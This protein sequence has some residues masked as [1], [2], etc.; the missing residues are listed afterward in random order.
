MDLETI[1]QSEVSQKEK[2]KY[3]SY[4][5][6]RNQAG[7]MW[8]PGVVARA[9]K[10][11]KEGKKEYEFVTRRGEEWMTRKRNQRVEETTDQ[12]LEKWYHTKESSF[13]WVLKNSKL[14]VY[15]DFYL[16]P[17]K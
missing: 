5:W 3:S 11:M 8:G 14:K 15:G 7:E 2:N 12:R 9:T 13:T 17:L 4:F 6:V 16:G 10:N 1:I